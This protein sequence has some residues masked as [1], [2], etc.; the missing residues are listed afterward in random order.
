MKILLGYPYHPCMV[1][2]PT[3]TI[4]INQ[5]EVNIPYMDGMGYI[6]AAFFQ[7]QMWELQELQ[8]LLS[9]TCDTNVWDPLKFISSKDISP[10]YIYNPLKSRNMAKI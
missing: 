4:K 6:L 1:Y 3:F 9:E 5:M 2:L 8:E 7:V 10:F